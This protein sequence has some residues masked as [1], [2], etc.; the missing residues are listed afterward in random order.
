MADIFRIGVS[1]LQAY[2]RALATTGHNVANANTPGYSRQRVLLSTQTPE[3]NGAGFLGTGVQVASIERVFDTFRASRLNEAT[4]GSARLEAYAEIAEGISNLV[5]SD[6]LGLGAGLSRLSGAMEDV[7]TDPTSI[8]ARQVLLGELEDLADVFHRISG[9]LDTQD[10]AVTQGLRDGARTIN[11]LSRGIADLNQKIVVASSSGN[12]PNDLLDARSN[13]LQR[14]SEQ[15][16]ITTVQESNGAINVFVGSGQALV[17]GADARELAVAT[18]PLDPQHPDLALGGVAV[19]AQLTGG[20]LGGLLDA[21]SELIA[22]TRNEVGRIAAALS[23]RVNAINSQGLD[24]DGQLGGALLG[25]P[26]AAVQAAATNTG[27]GSVAVRHADIGQLRADEYLLSF[28]GSGYQLR[29]ATTGT[30]VAMTGSGSAAD[31]FRAEGLE[32]VVTAGASAGDR[33][34]IQPV[35]TAATA[36]SVVE[37]DPR[38]IA[39]AAALTTAVDPA[40]TGTVRVDALEVIDSSATGFLD[41]VTI[42][43]TAPGTFMINGAGSYAYSPGS[44][45]ALSGYEITLSGTATTGDRMTVQ[46]GTGAVG[47]NS[48]G[49]R[50]AGIAREPILDG[51]AGSLGSANATLI[52]R[53]GSAA[54]QAGLARRAQEAIRTEAESAMAAVSGVNLDEEA[55]NLMRYQQAYQAMAQVI[56]VA[57]TTFQTLLAALRR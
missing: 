41:P 25:A 35:R 29:S 55:A 57:D 47:D 18:N 40:N 42:E 10:Q 49:L 50:L 54:Q 52:A 2:Q 31:P 44:P 24:L 9:Y 15:V 8:P 37:T 39:A 36:F 12:P 6:D 45:I 28:D 33:F 46:A 16:G 3:S 20:R 4:S 56:G 7:A 23:L 1:A 17:V 13:L 22:P 32:L 34:L 5:A 11:T 38:R 53:A 30:T 48:N 14:L 43:F 51:G 26:T 21:R 19:T 27:S